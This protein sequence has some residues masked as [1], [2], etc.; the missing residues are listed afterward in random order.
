MPLDTSIIS[1]YN[2]GAA[3]DV[4]A[5]LTQQMQGMQNI[6]TLERQRAQ[7]ALDMEDRAAAQAKEQAAGL[8]RALAPAVASV[9][10]DPSDEGLNVALSMVPEQ[11][12]EAMQAQV[13][14]LKGI[15]DLNRRKDV[16]R[17]ALVQDEIGQALLA[18]LEPSAN[19]RLNAEMAAQRAALDARRLQMEE[20]KLAM[21]EQMTPYQQAQIALE[22]QKIDAA[23]SKETAEETKK[24]LADEKRVKDL[25]L[26][27][28][29]LEGILTPG[30]LIDQ[31]TNSYLG[32]AADA[33]AAVVG[34]GTD[35][36]AAT[37]KIAPI[38]DLVLKM[39]PRF[40]GP[41]SNYDVQSYKDAAGN[42]ADPT[43]PNSIKRAAAEE[44]K[45]LFKKYQGQF[46]YAPDG[47]PASDRGEAPPA[48]GPPTISTDEEYDALPS[49]AEY[50]AP[51]G[52]RRRKR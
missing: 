34:W 30:G 23:K 22:Q 19:A 18:Q 41:Q 14:Q 27:V 21:G 16:V 28:S 5:M 20:N 32:A 26:V 45:R 8:A 42:L 31:S 7:D 35:S 52:V 11:Y 3:P 36:A 25:N 37:A 29:E 51:D 46:E 1:S 2:P 40:E 50:I 39:V 44:I 6:N 43:V 49:G 48:E 33:A 10:S 47:A 15:P 12:R 24:R 4:N 9:F 17:A 38:A 13:D